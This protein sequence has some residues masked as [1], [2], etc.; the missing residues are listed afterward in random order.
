M[1]RAAHRRRHAFVAKALGRVALVVPLSLVVPVGTVQH[2]TDLKPMITVTVGTEPIDVTPSTTFHDVVA[3][4][5]LAPKAGN[6]L[7]VEGQVLETALY[8]GRI[9]LNGQTQPVDAPLYNGWHIQVID[10]RNRTEGLTQDIVK[11]PGGRPGN[12]QF[13]L[14]T[15]PGEQVITK[16]VISGKVV[17]SVFRPTGPVHSPLEV[18]L[19]FDDGPWPDSTQQI[20]NILKKSHVP[21]TFFVIGTQ[22][23]A[24]PEL[25]HAELAAGM[26]V[27]NHSWDHPISP[28]FRD[29]PPKK[30]R[31]EIKHCRDVLRSLGADPTLFRPPGGSYSDRMIGIADKLGERLVLWSV[32]PHDWV[33]HTTPSRIVKAVMSAVRPGSII[34]LH[35]GGGD[36]SATVTALPRIIRRIRKMGLT[37]APIV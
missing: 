35:D 9:T 30:I 11:I 29:L 21:A 1:A 15:Q 6:L 19:T 31:G 5:G 17:S 24:R 27:E 36:Q 2:V 3:Q 28:P 26:D 22:A 14:G 20:L 8:P 10:G 7:D 18:A 37:F 4:L 33:D 34:L 12:P 13:F 25:I 32:D 23:Q 16:G